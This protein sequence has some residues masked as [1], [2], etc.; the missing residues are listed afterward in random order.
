MLSDLSLSM[1]FFRRSCVAL[2][3]SSFLAFL[4][5]I[6]VNWLVV[7]GFLLGVS[8]EVDSPSLGRADGSTA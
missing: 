3:I 4:V 7:A 8:S 1:V 6:G 2:R 5:R